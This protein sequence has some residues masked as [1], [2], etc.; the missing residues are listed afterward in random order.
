MLNNKKFNIVLS[1]LIAIGIWAYV[2]GETNP[3]AT[4]VYRDVPI[5]L[6]NQ[7]VLEANGLAISDVSAETLNV[8]LTG[9]RANINKTDIS[10]ITAWVDLADVAMGEN[11]LRVSIRVPD[12]VDIEDKSLNK[13]TITV[14]KRV[15]KE[16]KINPEYEGTF[17]TEEEP[18]TVEMNRDSVTVTG[19]ASLVEKVDHVCAKVSEGEVSEELRTIGCALVPV[20][21]KGAEIKRLELSA[22]SVQITAEL[23]TVKT[24]TLKVPVVDYSDGLD[25]KKITAPKTITIKGKSSTLDSIE[26]VTCEPV[27]ITEIEEDTVLTVKPVLPEGV[28]VSSRSSET[29]RVKI[30]VIKIQTKTFDFEAGEI[31]LKGLDENLNAEIKE[32]GT[33]KVSVS[34]K[35]EQLDAIEKE[36]ITLSV[37][38]TDLEK[39]THQVVLAVTCGKDSTTVAADP[40]EIRIVIE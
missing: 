38:L 22:K 2:I 4:K 1:L 21:E 25:E 14:D 18:I 26:S 11:Q 17:P 29:L 24:V 15:S 3:T 19:A 16:F 6:A 39:G 10:D 30:T 13:I 32:D 37:D 7:Q 27:D 8:T 31:Q 20:D 5:Q 33:I 40:E 35:A 36:D 23:A 9:T 28:Q 12:N 34:G